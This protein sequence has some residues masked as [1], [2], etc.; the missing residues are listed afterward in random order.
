MTFARYASGG[1]A[2][3]RRIKKN[4]WKYAVMQDPTVVGVWTPNVE[5]GRLDIGTILRGQGRNTR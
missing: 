3:I 2:G 1:E 4:M 5:D